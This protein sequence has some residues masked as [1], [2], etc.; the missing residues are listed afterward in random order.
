[1]PKEIMFTLYKIKI[2]KLQ[3]RDK[4]GN[5]ENFMW[6]AEIDDGITKTTFNGANK[7]KFLNHLREEIRI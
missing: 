7:K 4:L 1:M 6:I 3:N 5:M 2:K